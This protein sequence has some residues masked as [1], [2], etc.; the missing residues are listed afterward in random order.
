MAQDFRA[1]FGLGE[2]D[3]HIGTVDEE[4]VALAAIKAPTRRLTDKEREIQLLHD[5]H[6]LDEQRLQRLEGRLAAMESQL[7]SK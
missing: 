1:A 6:V 7:G 3:R 2:D 4:G 5:A